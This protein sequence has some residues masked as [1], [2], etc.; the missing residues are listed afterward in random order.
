M[1]YTK[2]QLEQLIATNLPTN[3]SNEIQAIDHRE[4]LLGL[5]DN[6]AFLSDINVIIEDH[7]DLITYKQDQVVVYSGELYRVITSTAL[8]NF[9][10]ANF[11]KIGGTADNALILQDNATIIKLAI[12]SP[13]I[14]LDTNFY[15]IPSPTTGSLSGVYPTTTE[16]ILE[17]YKGITES[18]SIYKYKGIDG[19]D[20]IKKGTNDWKT[21]T[22][23]NELYV[24]QLNHG[25]NVGDF[26][27]MDINGQWVKAINDSN[28]RVND[29]FCTNIVLNVYD[30]N[31]FI[32]GGNGSILEKNLGFGAVPVSVYL[33]SSDNGKGQS[34]TPDSDYIQQV[35]WTDGNYMYFNPQEVTNNIIVDAGTN[36]IT[37]GS[38][39]AGTNGLSNFGDNIGLGGT[40]TENVSIVGENKVIETTISTSSSSYRNQITPGGVEMRAWEIAQANQASLIATTSSASINA[41]SSVNTSSSITVGNTNS[42]II[43]TDNIS[44]IGIVYSDDYSANY[45]SRSLVDKAYADSVGGGGTTSQGTNGLSNFGDN[46]GL[47]GLVTDD[48]SI[49]AFTP[50]TIKTG[51]TVGDITRKIEVNSNIATMRVTN[52]ITNELGVVDVYPYGS[53]MGANNSSGNNSN[54]QVNT[55]SNVGLL[56][57]DDIFTVGAKYNADYSVNGILDDRWIPDY[58]AVKDY[59]DSLVTSEVI[60]DKTDSFILDILSDGIIYTQSKVSV[61]TATV[62]TGA[63]SINATCEI[64]QGEIGDINLV[65]GA[66]VNFIGLVLGTSS[67]GDSISLRR[68]NDNSFGLTGEVYKIY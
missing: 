33:S 8:G 21:E 37:Q 6:L 55:L 4:V 17:V 61:T 25:F 66:G 48:I 47:G 10:L 16:G 29:S 2:A 68:L 7:S 53:Y 46:I 35:G 24:T 38:V 41:T 15:N 5:L 54:I 57:T 50:V 9:D 58:K 34:N 18:E 63:L 52:N 64:I 28:S 22:K 65:A 49:E 13:I 11:E 59:A 3:G 30:S 43:A 32:L 39:S 62:N 60:S 27:Y 14:G 40:L 67:Q 20:Y 26:I 23:Y 36:A 56:I 51:V 31:S 12:D 19:I 45:T 44:N 1:I 42:G